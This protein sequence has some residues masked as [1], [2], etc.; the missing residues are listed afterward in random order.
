MLDAG[1]D[2]EAGRLAVGEHLVERIELGHRFEDVEGAAHRVETV[3]EQHDPAAIVCR[4]PARL[5][6]SESS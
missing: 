1:D 3:H 6:T 4:A 5:P 2:G